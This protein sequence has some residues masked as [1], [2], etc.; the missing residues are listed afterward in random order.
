M[1][2]FLKSPVTFMLHN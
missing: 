2:F 1:F